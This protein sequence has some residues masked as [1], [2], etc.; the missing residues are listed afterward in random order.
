MAARLLAPLLLGIATSFSPPR[1]AT[2]RGH[3]LRRATSFAPPQH[4]T[5]H[6]HALRRA[7]SSVDVDVADLGVTLE[8]LEEMAE[9]W[10]DVD[11]WTMDQRLEEGGEDFTLRPPRAP[12]WNR[13]AV[14]SSRTP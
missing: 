1:H 7:S 4:A 10:L 6:T 5:R 13:P 14:Q 12:P 3:A 8:D 9:T 2:H 11:D